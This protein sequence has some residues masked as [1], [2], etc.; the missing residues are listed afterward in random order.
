MRKKRRLNNLW[1]FNNNIMFAVRSL[2][3]LQWNELVLCSLEMQWN[4]DSVVGHSSVLSWSVFGMR[5]STYAV[6]IE[7]YRSLRARAF[8]FFH[9]YLRCL[10]CY[11]CSRLLKTRAAGRNWEWSISDGRDTLLD[12]LID[13]LIVNSSSNSSQREIATWS[14]RMHRLRARFNWFFSSN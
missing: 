9:V 10:L 14:R 3:V 7:I 2:H 11:C 4:M 12:I 6:L 5:A 1:F 13:Y 8:A